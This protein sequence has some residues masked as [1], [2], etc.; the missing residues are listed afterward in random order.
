VEVQD[1]WQ[2]AIGA[3]LGQSLDALIV[4]DWDA[5]CALAQALAGRTTTSVSLVAH[6]EVTKDHPP[7]IDDLPALA[8][9]AAVRV[10][11][12]GPPRWKELDGD[13]VRRVVLALLGDCLVVG[14]LTAARDL[15]RAGLPPGRSRL[16]TRDGVVMSE[17]G[18]LRIWVGGKPTL[19]SAQQ[20]GHGPAVPLAGDMA[21][22]Q[23]IQQVRADAER[24]HE[25]ARVAAAQIH[26]IESQLQQ[27]L[28]QSRDQQ[29]VVSRRKQALDELTALTHPFESQQVEWRTTVR[30]AQ[31][32][33]EAARRQV[34]HLEE[35]LHSGSR[36]AERA[37]EQL[38][39]LSQQAAEDGEWLDLPAGLGSQ[40]VFEMAADADVPLALPPPDLEA[41]IRELRRRLRTLGPVDIEA[42]HE[43]E[44]A[45]QR[46]S[47]LLGQS[48]DLADAERDLI[49][50]LDDLATQLEARFEQHFA[51]VAARFSH[52]YPRLTDGGEGR[53]ELTDGDGQ[54]GIEISVRPPAKRRQPLALL[55]GGERAQTAAALVFA[56]LDASATPFCFLDEV[57]SML[58]EANI[59]R[60][61]AAL[62]DLAQRTQCVVITHNRGTIECADTIYGLTMGSDGASRV[63]ALR[64]S[65]ERGE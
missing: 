54:R 29:H 46:H 10:L 55:S 58:D 5:A 8:A 11:D 61:R 26:A 1:G 23:F 47:F 62:T 18:V 37:Q 33:L 36:D 43:F 56:L 3:A 65:Q 28:A 53:L 51:E 32:D 12:V 42:L 41:R 15:L 64:M 7:P 39:R 2:A 22:L 24:A 45:A 13:A 57:D 20:T 60:F 14:E 17:G 9:E 50:L 59:D 49:G 25:Q 16:A 21:A 63:L 34:T 48:E 44:E 27:T 35:R 6:R 4:R 30:Q 40:L 38:E 19:P 31:D 52:Y